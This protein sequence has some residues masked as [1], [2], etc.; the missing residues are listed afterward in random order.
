MEMPQ[1]RET[2]EKPGENTSNEIIK[3]VRKLRWVGMEEEAERLLKKLKRGG[4]TAED[5]VLASPRDTD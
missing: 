1:E 3:L 5:S 4:A 2:P